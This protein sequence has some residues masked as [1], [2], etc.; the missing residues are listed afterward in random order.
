MIIQPVAQDETTKLIL[1]LISRLFLSQKLS[2]I[3]P[4][5]YSF[6][7]FIKLYTRKGIRSIFF[8][9]LYPKGYKYGNGL[10]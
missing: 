1:L 6:L 7:S 10:Q 4:I 2:K 5:G 3:H 9:N 8:V